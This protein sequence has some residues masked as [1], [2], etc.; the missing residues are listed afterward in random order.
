MEKSQGCD[1]RPLRA[2]KGA[3]R[4]GPFPAL[5]ACLSVCVSVCVSVR[6]PAC[7]SFLVRF[8]PDPFTSYPVPSHPVLSRSR[9]VPVPSRPVPSRLSVCLYVLA[10]LCLCLALCLCPWLRAGLSV[11]VP[12]RPAGRLSVRLRLSIFPSARPSVRLSVC[13][14]RRRRQFARICAAS[15]K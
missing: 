12:V 13:P 14:Q 5:S 7:L 10:C 15:E 6:L 4:G 11:C 9:P 2:E 1:G 3:P 8:C